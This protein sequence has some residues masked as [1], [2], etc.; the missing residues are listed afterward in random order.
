MTTMPAFCTPV[1]LPTK[2]S[3]SSTATSPRRR[4][5]VVAVPRTLPR[6]TA[7]VTVA[8]KD[9]SES[10]G[11]GERFP[12]RLVGLYELKRLGVDPEKMIAPNKSAER[13]LGALVG[14]G[15]LATFAV[16]LISPWV[17][18]EGPVALV[19]AGVLTL[20]AVD[21]LALSGLLQR[22][23]SVQLQNTRRVALHEAGHFLVAHLLG[24]KVAGYSL[25]SARTVIAGEKLGVEIEEA[26]DGDA[27]TLAA[28]GMAGIAAECSVYGDSQGGAEDFAEVARVA[29][30]SG[31]FG[32]AT[33]QQ[34][35]IIV[36]WG[37]MQAV[38]LLK[39]HSDALE[40]LTTAMINN[41]DVSGCVRIIDESVNAEALRLKKETAVSK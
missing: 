7:S 39:A 18:A 20:W 17:Q 11:R 32:R 38:S 31:P 37:L 1:L 13:G 10:F 21:T 30:N 23:A 29:R 8:D 12:R 9:V 4:S 36:R 3:L 25:P 40:K 6:A 35:T 15:V 2:T 22:A 34:K 26:K 41:E 14:L 24:L 33:E 27:Y 16:P 5:R 19:I 28:L